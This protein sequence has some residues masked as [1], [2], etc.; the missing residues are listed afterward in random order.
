MTA[1]EIASAVGA[2]AAREL[3]KGIE[4]REPSAT[5]LLASGQLDLEGEP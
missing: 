5:C 4:G 3:T 2:E 1:D